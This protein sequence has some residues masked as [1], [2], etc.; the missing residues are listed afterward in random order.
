MFPRKD[1]FLQLRK[2]LKAVHIGNEMWTVGKIAYVDDPTLGPFGRRAIRRECTHTAW[3]TPWR[4]RCHC[5]DRPSR[6]ASAF[7]LKHLVADGL[8]ITV[9]DWLDPHHGFARLLSQCP[10]GDERNLTLPGRV[11]RLDGPLQIQAIG[12]NRSPSGPVSPGTSARSA[13][14]PRHA[15]TGRT[16]RCRPPC[17]VSAATTEASSRHRGWTGRRPANRG[18]SSIA[19]DKHRDGVEIAR[20][21]SHAE[22]LGFEGYRSSATERVEDRRWVAVEAPID[23]RLG[24]GKDVRIV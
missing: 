8:R 10:R 14:T 17:P 4:C 7:H 11:R 3:R 19:L 12:A 23:L 21:G 18:I 5:H 2:G 9:D 13:R 1:T 16:P 15:S 20:Q 24:C 6:R 22:P